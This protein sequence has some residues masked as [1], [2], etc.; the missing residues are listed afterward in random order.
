MVYAP[1]N[2]LSLILV[3]YSISY[4]GV[5]K[6]FDSGKKTNIA[7]NELVIRKRGGGG[8]GGGAGGGG[9]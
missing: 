4:S 8:G 2:N 1:V 3:R 5:S 9:A 6:L 7:Y